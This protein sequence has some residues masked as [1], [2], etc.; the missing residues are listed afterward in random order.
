MCL[1]KRT[2]CDFTLPR[3]NVPQLLSLT[4]F[5]CVTTTQQVDLSL[6]D[7]ELVD[8]ASKLYIVGNGRLYRCRGRYGGRYWR[9]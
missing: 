2:P 3:P 6:P 9:A 7:S 5:I 8:R 4:Y 1:C